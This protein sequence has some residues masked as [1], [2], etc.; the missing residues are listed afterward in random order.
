MTLG[1][2]ID[3]ADN[4]MV[5]EVWDEGRRLFEVSTVYAADY[6]LVEKWVKAEVDTIEVSDGL[7]LKVTLEV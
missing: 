3:K 2:L 5:I 4:Q 1:E 7:G 6:L